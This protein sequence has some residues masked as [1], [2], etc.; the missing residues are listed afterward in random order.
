METSGSYHHGELRR[1]LLDAA[2]EI[3]RE[4]GVPALS[5][6]GVARR[7]GVSHM[8][9]YHHFANRAELVAAL[10][11][12]GFQRL[13]EQMRRG[14]DAG[15]GDPME[16]LRA[17]GVAYVV[18]AVENP[19]MFRLMFGRELGDSSAHPELQR[20]AGEAYATFAAALP[21]AVGGATDGAAAGAA[22]QTAD[23]RDE[24]RTGGVLP[25]LPPIALAA[26]SLV[27]G[28]ATLLVEGQ[29]PGGA[30]DA[31]EA[32]RLTREAMGALRMAGKGR[33]P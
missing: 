9:P 26:W 14:M 17:C 21:G 4:S 24:H 2:G 16:R 31:S 23:S 20:A 13:A 22:S 28:L 27:H 29:V 25:A 8:A 1:A 19:E 32:E 18:F 3:L 15:A 30:A 5:L 7:T 6:R 10:A 11:A 12:R 33:S